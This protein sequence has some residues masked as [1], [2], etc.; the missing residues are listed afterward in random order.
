[1]SVEFVTAEGFDFAG[2]SDWAGPA[3]SCN[4]ETWQSIAC[5]ICGDDIHDGQQIGQVLRNETPWHADDSGDAEWAAIVWHADCD[6][7]AEEKRIEE[8][9]SATTANPF[10][11]KEGAKE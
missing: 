8:A 10:T 6:A 5:A 3:E 7:V 2:C 1:M 9:E 11:P 4:C